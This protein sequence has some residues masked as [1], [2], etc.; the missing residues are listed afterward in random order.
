MLKKYGKLLD[1]LRALCLS[2]FTVSRWMDNPQNQRWG[3]QDPLCSMVP[4]PTFP[5]SFN[6]ILPLPARPRN[7]GC[8]ERRSHS[9]ERWSQKVSEA[10]GGG[11]GL[12]PPAGRALRPLSS[13]ATGWGS[14][15]AH[16]EAEVP[17]TWTSWDLSPQ[18]HHLHASL[19][20]TVGPQ[21]LRRQ[22]SKTERQ[23]RLAVSYKKGLQTVGFQKQIELWF[24]DFFEP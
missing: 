24:S 13:L 19:C 6:W 21:S 22:W 20:I 2:V 11:I 3:R 10:E 23:S 9:G 16:R 4:C 5:I 18:A 12:S 7:L 17:L 15:V 8:R 14:V 1:S